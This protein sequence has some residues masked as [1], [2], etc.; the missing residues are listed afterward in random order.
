MRSE[1][2]DMTPLFRRKPAGRSSQKSTTDLAAL[3][4]TVAADEGVWLPRLVLPSRAER[5]WTRLSSDGEVD[6]WLLSWLPGHSTDLHDHGASA[7]AFTVVR[8]SLTELRQGA[9]R[10]LRS[11]RRAAGSV[12][13]IDAGVVHDVH[14]AGNSPTV[15]IHAYSP[16]LREMNYYDLDASGEL[17]RIGSVRTTEPERES[18]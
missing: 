17:H 9:D 7:A 4:H 3:V 16:P 10:R 6:V 18:A 1:E 5:R 2:A 8:G 15:S 12:T 11:F 14:G 13:T